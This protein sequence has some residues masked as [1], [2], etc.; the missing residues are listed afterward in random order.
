M[1]QVNHNIEIVD[2]ETLTGRLTQAN[3]SEGGCTDHEFALDELS[4]SGRV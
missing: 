4:N 1:K 3:E 2:T